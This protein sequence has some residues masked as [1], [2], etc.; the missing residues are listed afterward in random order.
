V[1]KAGF[2]ESTAVPKSPPPSSCFNIGGFDLRPI[3]NKVIIYSIPGHNSN[4]VK[5]SLCG[6][7]L[8]WFSHFLSLVLMLSF[9]FFVIYYYALLLIVIAVLKSRS[10]V[11][12]QACPAALREIAV[13]RASIGPRP[14]CFLCV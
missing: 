5:Y 1:Y 4:G 13:A 11:G 2:K 7:L 8:V 10:R 3:V 14:V 12:R 6:T 9:I